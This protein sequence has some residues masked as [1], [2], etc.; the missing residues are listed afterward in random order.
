MDDGRIMMVVVVVM[1][2]RRIHGN[3]STNLLWT[4]F[5][6]FINEEKLY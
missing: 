6:L 5:G 1:V 3:E 4:T 2:G